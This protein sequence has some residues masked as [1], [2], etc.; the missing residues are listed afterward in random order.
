MREIVLNSYGKINL[1]LDIV[2]KRDDGYHNIE[3]IMQEIGLKDLVY[4]KEREEGI[5]I[6][7]NCRELPLDE[8]NLVYKAWSL[9]KEVSG[10]DKGVEIYIE[11]NIPIAAGL[12]GGSSNGAAVLK[13]LNSLWGL[14]YSL[15]KLQAIAIDIGADLPFCLQ[16]GTCYA[17][18]V[19][20]ILEP[21]K[22]FKDK[23]ILLANFG[24]P[25]S[26]REVY[27]SLNLNNSKR[28][29]DIR[30]KV[31]F[32]EDD[33]LLGLAQS[34]ENIMETVVLK[35]YSELRDIKNIMLE[36]GALGS[37]MSGSG[38]TIFGIFNDEEKILSCSKRLKKILDKVYITK[39]I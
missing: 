7:S 37:L 3:T 17:R 27:E 12:A 29:I 31:K 4:I 16:G 22:S 25:I 13:G 10:L 14:N 5:V 39:T 36:E 34:M 21:L 19:G 30:S 15:E 8:S 26:S 6:N 18:G 32:I 1:S 35:E 23:L 38:P 24:L 33:N 28:E 11:K 2:N 9:M 20:E